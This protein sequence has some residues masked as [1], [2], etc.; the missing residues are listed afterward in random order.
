MSQIMYTN[1]SH[2]E[3]QMLRVGLNDMG[4]GYFILDQQGNFLQYDDQAK[5]IFAID[6]TRSWET[7][8][9]SRVDSILS[10][11]L[12]E[13]LDNII[14]H[15]MEF[16]KKNISCTN[17]LGKFMTLDIFCR[18]MEIDDFPGKCAIG[19]IE[20]K[21]SQIN[22]NDIGISEFQGLQIL[23]E[24]AAALSSANE[25]EHILNVILTGATASQGLGFNRAF[26]FMYDTDNKILKGH[27]AVG[28]SSAEEAGNI[29]K[30]LD[31]KRLSLP[32][33]FENDIRKNKITNEP[34][35]NL[36]K[37]ISVD[38]NKDSIISNL[39]H[40]AEWV[41]LV[42]ID[43]YD[44][45]TLKLTDTL[46][47]KKMALVPMVSKGRLTGLLA[48][49]NYITG[50]PISDKSIQLLQILAN[51]GAVA[52]ERANL[53]REQKER[54]EQLE[55]MNTLLAESQEQLIKIE[56]MSVIGELTASVAHEL[57]NPLTI[58]GGFAGLLLKDSL[59]DEQRE[60][61]NIISSEIKRAESVLSEVLDFSKASKSP[62]KII[63]YNNLIN[64]VLTLALSRQRNPEFPLALEH[65]KLLVYGN[66]DQLFHAF[67]QFFQ[68]IIEELMPTAKA[69]ARIE[70]DDKMAS[71]LIK[72]TPDPNNR[73][74]VIKTLK[75]VFSKS[76][77]SLRLTILVA[78]EAIKSHN[79]NFGLNFNKN[80]DPTLY[81]E[82][83]LVKENDFEA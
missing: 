38:L 18:A 56:K 27:L 31:A 63:D 22:A 70:H 82:L 68:L 24:V 79:G 61:L 10:T 26:L 74:A 77:A 13:N 46:G 62:S 34:L 47:T 81:I 3:L 5:K 51:Q 1:N 83:P 35:S 42:D 23:S 28:P 59:N 44:E 48:A 25:L 58:V 75:Q 15:E 6:N 49:D 21:T 8:N 66:Y 14:N 52:L 64:K 9:I 33:L 78:N 43:N 19:F 37:N 65:H 54:A 67:Y 53:Y 72:L 16:S 60:Y 73:T 71:L 12:S 17:R 11:G 32:E 40:N 55:K 30:E 80:N 50:Q 69:E 7:L 76:K 20:D 41:N 36:I 29:W 2:N 4:I 45:I 57:R 39:C